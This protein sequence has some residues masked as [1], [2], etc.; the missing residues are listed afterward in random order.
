MSAAA[1]AAIESGLDLRRITSIVFAALE[2]GVMLLLLLGFRI[3][4]SKPKN[5][6]DQ[7]PIS[8]PVYRDSKMLPGREI[9]CLIFSETFLNSLM[10]L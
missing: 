8:R 9:I 4:D 2:E 6:D 5:V 7:T 10:I 1:A 3:T